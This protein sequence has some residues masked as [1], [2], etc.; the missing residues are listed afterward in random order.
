MAKPSLH[1]FYLDLVP[2]LLREL[3]FYIPETEIPKDIIAKLDVFKKHIDLNRVY[4][5]DYHKGPILYTSDRD[6][7]EITI[8]SSKLEK[9]LFNLVEKKSAASPDEFQYILD[10]YFELVETIFYITDWMHTN[11]K[12]H[13]KDVT[14]VKDLF[15]LQLVFYKKHFELLVKTFYPNRAAIPRGNFNAHNMIDTYFPDISKSYNVI[16]KMPATVQ[17]K[18][19]INIPK[20]VNKPNMK[21]KKSLVTEVEAERLL[22]RTFFNIGN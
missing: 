21:I 15:Y 17:N 7:V 16:T 10:K 11:L 2:N 3:Y 8:K 12:A 14:P 4:V 6:A 20:T 22:L 5:I 1:Q 19:I 18:P 13:I 9:N